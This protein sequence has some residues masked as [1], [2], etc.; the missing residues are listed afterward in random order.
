MEEDI[1]LNSAGLTLT[2]V[3]GVSGNGLVIRHLK[4][5]IFTEKSS[6]S[7]G[8]YV[9]VADSLLKSK[10]GSVIT[11]YSP[12]N[13]RGDLVIHN[14]NTQVRLPVGA[15]G[16][17]LAADSTNS[18]GVVWK[19]NSKF[20]GGSISVITE[21]SVYSAN[22]PYTNFSSIYGG[23]S[24]S[25]LGNQVLFGVPGYITLTYVSE[26]NP[27]DIY[28]VINDEHIV[29]TPK[30]SSTIT[31]S[32][33][34]F[35][36]LELVHIFSKCTVKFRSSWNFNITFVSN[37]PVL[38]VLSSDQTINLDDVPADLVLSGIPSGMINW[39]VSEGDEFFTAPTTTLTSSLTYTSA[40]I[41]EIVNSTS[42]RA[43]V[44]YIINDTVVR[45]YSNHI[46]IV[47]LIPDP[48]FM[49]AC[50]DFSL[51]TS[52]GNITNSGVSPYTGLIGTNS[53]IIA[54]FGSPPG[55][56]I[57]QVDAST[58]ACAD[59]LL[60]VYN[61]IRNY[62]PSPTSHGAIFGNG[63]TLT[64]GTYE[65]I[66]ASSLAGTLTLDGTGDV[67]SLFLFIINGALAGGAGFNMVLI[68]NANPYNIYWSIPGAFSVGANS[69]VTG[70]FICFAGAIDIGNL[71]QAN[72]RIFT[73]AG[74]ITSANST[75]DYEHQ[76]E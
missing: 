8:F 70:T 52:S 33:V 18:N 51:F 49:L 40:Q 48:L 34:Y 54:G 72:A 16:R 75:F 58:Q 22:G 74:A 31:T 30:N 28:L 57:R 29:L 11:T 69:D 53:G 60:S 44:N 26:N 46:R 13:T 14:E 45:R 20:I 38:L 43:F 23:H 5:I 36:S 27:I 71:S 61:G 1:F 10:N 19:L 35:S 41:G 56:G 67:R 4:N 50:K 63:E 66:G 65:T 39:Q 64:P 3:Q 17:I 9:D 55:P 21:N 32:P 47:V 62:T 68:N 24:V 73:I 2:D 12:S 7:G 15:D 59:N 37:N 42:Y 25:K 76:L 6:V